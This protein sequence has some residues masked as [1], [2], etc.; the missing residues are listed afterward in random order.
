MPLATQGR[1]RDVECTR[2]IDWFLGRG[3]M[4]HVLMPRTHIIFLHGLDLSLR[5]VVW[6]LDV[7]TRWGF[8]F[9]IILVRIASV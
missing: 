5:T 3:S 7:N 1:Y 6:G 2:M 8:L 4:F 9:I